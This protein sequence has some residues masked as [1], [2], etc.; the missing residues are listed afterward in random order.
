MAES[1]VKSYFPTFI[2]GRLSNSKV[3]SDTSL[4]ILTLKPKSEAKYLCGLEAEAVHE[5]QWRHVKEAMLLGVPVEPSVQTLK[6]KCRDCGITK[7][8]LSWLEPYSRITKRLKSYIEQ[9]LPP[10]P[11]K[12]ISQLMYVHWH[13]IKEIDKR[14]LRQVVPPVKWE[15]LRQLVMDEFAISK[16]H[17]YATVIAKTHQVIWVGLGRSRKDIRPFLEQL[18][19]HGNNIEAVAMDM[20][21]AF[22]L[23]V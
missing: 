8:S 13:T 4:I 1:H 18:G 5:Y 20:N 23:E 9:L 12:H 7:E 17:R 15:E 19:K 22:D 10:L 11:I 16:G 21:T 2:L 3:S 14:R 6:I